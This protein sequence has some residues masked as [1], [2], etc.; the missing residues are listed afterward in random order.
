MI[1]SY[2]K[3]ETIIIQSDINDVFELID[4]KIIS[5]K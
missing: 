4:T 1:Y 2:S 3:V 5:N